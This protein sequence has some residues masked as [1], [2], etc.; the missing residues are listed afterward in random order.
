MLP[1]LPPIM[2]GEDGR[3][4]GRWKGKGR[5]EG[6]D[7]VSL[8]SQRSLANESTRSIASLILPVKVGKYDSTLFSRKVL[9]VE[10]P[11]H[12]VRWASIQP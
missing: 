4:R 7:V 3:E 1:P 12:K 10:I 9:L 2:E 11:I 6:E 8:T 5:M